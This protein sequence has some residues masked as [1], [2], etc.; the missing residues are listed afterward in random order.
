MFTTRYTF[1]IQQASDEVRTRDL[2]LTKGTPYR[3]ATEAQVFVWFRLYIGFRTKYLYIANI[4]NA[5]CH[6]LFVRFG[7]WVLVFAFQ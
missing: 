1:I 7:F 5:F 6:E 3:W 2:S 4:L